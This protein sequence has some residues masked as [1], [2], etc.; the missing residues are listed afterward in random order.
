MYGPTHD[1]W[2]FGEGERAYTDFW[3]L[4]RRSDAPVRFYDDPLHYLAEVLST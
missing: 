2:L 1:F 3:D 4:L